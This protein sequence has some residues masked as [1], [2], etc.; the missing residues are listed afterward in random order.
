[1]FR[2]SIEKDVAIDASPDQLVKNGI[3]EDEDFALRTRDAGEFREGERY[4]R[5]ENETPK[6]LKEAVEYV[7]GVLFHA[8]VRVW[9]GGEMHEVTAE[10]LRGT[11]KPTA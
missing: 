5:V 8:P 7:N 6:N 2:F 4:F 1:M 11:R 10:T 9:L 3:T